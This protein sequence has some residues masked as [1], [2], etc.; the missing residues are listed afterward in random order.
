MDS[1]AILKQL[2]DIFIDVLDNDKI[3]LTMETAAKDIEEWDSLNHIQLVV[4]VEKKFK[5]RFTSAEIN[6]WK[7]VG[8]MA[9]AIEKKIN[10]YISI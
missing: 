1:T 7:T 9:A 3:K 10:G 2:N 4:A 8:D 5:L 6:G